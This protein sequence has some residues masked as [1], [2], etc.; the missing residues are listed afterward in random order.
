MNNNNLIVA[1]LIILVALVL[2]SYPS[3]QKNK[4]LTGSA[5]EIQV[6][7]SALIA[8]YFAIAASN[9]LTTDGIK[10][11]GLNPGDIDV[12]ADGNNQAGTSNY[13]ITISSDSNVNVDLCIKASAPLTSGLN[14]IPLANYRWDSDIANPLLA[15]AIAMDLAYASADTNIVPSNSDYYRFWL[16]VPGSQAAG[17]YTNTISFKGVQTGNVC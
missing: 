1:A 4:G 14:T 17:T 12:N 6:G 2:I 5:T 8:N 7:S 3:F 10:W 13:F 15:S 9:V 11:S 16:S